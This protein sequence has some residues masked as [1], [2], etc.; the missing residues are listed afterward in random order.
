VSSGPGDTA[1]DRSSTTPREGEV[2]VDRTTSSAV[3]R[4]PAEPPPAPG[5]GHVAQV[6]VPLRVVALVMAV[7]LVGFT[8]WIMWMAWTLFAEG[9]MDGTAIGGFLIALPVLLLPLAGR[10]WLAARR[11]VD[12]EP[13]GEVVDAVESSAF[14]EAVERHDRLLEAQRLAAEEAGGVVNAE[15]RPEGPDSRLDEPTDR[16]D[17]AR[18]AARMQERGD[19]G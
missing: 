18:I 14:L 11:G 7:G 10:L 5:E 9:V 3:E 13:E 4:G 12:P 19:P 8:G 1:D 16:G 2:I 15:S 17:E 6:A